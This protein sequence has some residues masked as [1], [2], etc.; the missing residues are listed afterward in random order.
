M[1]EVLFS[2]YKWENW[3][4]IANTPIQ[5]KKKFCELHKINLFVTLSY[6][7]NAYMSAVW[8]HRQEP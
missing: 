1:S 5:H 7:S 2:E 4:Q 3:W 6:C 8:T